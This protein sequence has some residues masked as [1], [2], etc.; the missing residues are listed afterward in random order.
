MPDDGD[1]TPTPLGRVPTRPREVIR[2]RD[3]DKFH[4]S[5]EEK[6]RKFEQQPEGHEFIPAMMHLLQ[7][8]VDGREPETMTER[9]LEAVFEQLDDDTEVLHEAVDQYRELDQDLK[10]RSLSTRYLG[11]PVD[12]VI[13][14]SELANVIG[15]SNKAKGSTRGTMA[16]GTKMEYCCCPCGGTQPDETPAPPERDEFQVEFSHLYCVDESNPE[17]PGSDSPYVAFAVTT[18][19]MVES[20]TPA[21]GVNTP[22]YEGVNDGDKRPDDGEEDLSLYGKAAAKPIDSPFLIAGTCMEHD[23]GVPS[24]VSAGLR[25]SLTTV[26]TT[27]A[28]IGGPAGWIVAGAAAIGVGVT[29]LVDLWGE[30]DQIGDVET[31]GMTEAQAESLTGS[32]NLRVLNPMH[33]DGG[34]TDGIYDAYLKLA[35]S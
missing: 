33:F 5:I 32:V 9:R 25:A 8:R 20:S 26:A 30:D 24:K 18:E 28:G 11:Y 14:D 31:R 15:R 17:W 10:A 13:P 35:R 12:E 3:S 6:V 19:E 21:W 16:T 4:T 34:S 2:S 22:I 23:N 27:A 1:P 29:F 7:R